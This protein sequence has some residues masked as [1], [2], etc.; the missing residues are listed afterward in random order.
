MSKAT[1]KQLGDI[2]IEA[3]TDHI[4]TDKAAEKLS[5]ALDAEDTANLKK[6][7][8]SLARFNKTANLD[9]KDAAIWALGALELHGAIPLP[10]KFDEEVVSSWKMDF[11]TK[12]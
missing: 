12:P 3:L 11:K 5:I 8:D 1:S 2:V 7:S 10:K 9:P 4:A 6:V